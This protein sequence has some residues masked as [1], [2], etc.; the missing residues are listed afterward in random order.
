[1]FFCLVTFPWI[2]AASYSAWS[3]SSFVPPLVTTRLDFHSSSST[4]VFILDSWTFPAVATP[5]PSHPRP[6]LPP[7][8]SSSLPR[9]SSNPSFLVAASAQHLTAG[10]S[11]IHTHK[12]LQTLCSE[13]CAC[14]TSGI[15]SKLEPIVNACFQKKMWHYVRLNR[16]GWHKWVSQE[17]D[18]IKFA[19][20]RKRKRARH[21]WPGK[22][23]SKSSQTMTC[24]IRCSTSIT[25]SI[26]VDITAEVMGRATAC[27]KPCCCLSH[28]IQTCFT[29]VQTR[30]L[31]F[32]QRGQ[33]DCK[34]QFKAC[35]QLN[36]FGLMINHRFNEKLKH[37]ALPD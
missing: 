13:T 10:D 16:P 4:S 21:F 34:Q 36:L 8:P 2:Y 11:L 3:I 32:S 29:C 14:D 30:T 18:W 22:H 37:V 15:R 9:F 19:E 24:I 7:P 25:E 28:L 20:S 12:R 26:Q 1:M 27:L 6:P 5:S 35:W 23:I 17:M 33:F 31:L